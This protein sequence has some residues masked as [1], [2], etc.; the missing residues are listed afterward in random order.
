[1]QYA[2]FTTVQGL[3]GAYRGVMRCVEGKSTLWWCGFG[4][5]FT[6]GLVLPPPR[7]SHNQPMKQL[8]GRSLNQPF[9]SSP[10]VE[11]GQ[12][13]LLSPWRRGLIRAWLPHDA[14]GEYLPRRSRIPVRKNLLIIVIAGLMA[15]LVPLAAVSCG[16]STGATTSNYASTTW[17]SITTTTFHVITTTTTTSRPD[18]R[19]YTVGSGGPAGGLVF[20]DKGDDS[21][22]WR[23]LE[24]APASTEWAN[25]PWGDT[26]FVLQGETWTEV[27]TGKRNTA[28]IV[29]AQGTGDAYAAQLCDALTSGGFSDWFLP[30]RDELWLMYD[31]LERLGLGGFGNDYYWSSSSYHVGCALIQ[32]FPPGM[33][34]YADAGYSLRVR[35]ARAF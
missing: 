4:A 1:M 23:Y 28:T 18:T 13:P 14:R 7:P 8:P 9:T 10:G 25:V 5:P 26:G 27:G 15:G 35:A 16:G 24:A 2:M 21:G 17:P 3:Y 29:A 19:D 31:N 20:Y 32:G 34:N 33:Y 6:G 11:T 22:G 12:V 30:S